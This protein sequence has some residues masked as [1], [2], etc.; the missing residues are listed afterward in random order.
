MRV[1]WSCE[2]N[3]R[4]GL[5]RSARGKATSVGRLGAAPRLGCAQHSALT[6]CRSSFRWTGAHRS[7]VGHGDGERS[8]ATQLKVPSA[9]V[10]A[11]VML[12]AKWQQVAE[13]GATTIAIPRD[14]MHRARIKP[15]F[16]PG[17]SARRVQRTKR[18]P[19]RCA[20]KP[21]GAAE[22]E[23]ARRVQYDAV[24]YHDTDHVTSVGQLREDRARQFNREPPVHCA[25]WPV[26]AS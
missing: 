13:V 18:T 26:C 21:S 6:S 7:S 2:S 12:G 11:V 20:G 19:L 14:V 16:T 17:N 24:A 25:S 1:E 5:E 15:S 10:H 8:V 9:V 22:V 3:S 23:L 4:R